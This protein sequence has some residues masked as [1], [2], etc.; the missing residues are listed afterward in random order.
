M[1]G[2]WTSFEQNPLRKWASGSDL[3]KASLTMVPGKDILFDDI[4]DIVFNLLYPV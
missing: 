1:T 4:A 2:E 3:I